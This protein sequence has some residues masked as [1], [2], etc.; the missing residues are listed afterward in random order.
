M[1]TQQ[2]QLALAWHCAF[3]LPCR[4]VSSQR[5]V[6]NPVQGGNWG[7][8]DTWG[9]RLLA[10]VGL[11]VTDGSRQQA[12]AACRPPDLVGSLRWGR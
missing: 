3:W 12:A 5:C 7:T 4:R 1:A 9:A 10:A 2:S 11:P 8:L 6:W